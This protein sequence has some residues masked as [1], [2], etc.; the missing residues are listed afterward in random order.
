MNAYKKI[1][2]YILNNPN[3][4]VKY[5]SQEFNT[6]YETVK[7]KVEKMLMMGFLIG[8]YNRLVITKKGFEFL[9]GEVF[10]YNFKPSSLYSLLKN[11]FVNDSAQ[12]ITL[13]RVI[14]SKKKNFNFK[15]LRVYRLLG[16]LSVKIERVRKSRTNK[17]IILLTKQGL[18]FL[19]FY[20]E[21]LRY[22]EVLHDL[23]KTKN[24]SE[25]V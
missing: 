14:L 13:E 21:K 8:N 15:T 12:T 20:D 16:F 6:S 2:E 10:F 23:K 18:D 4:S 11:L 17:Y 19:Q 5:I 3:T 25:V 9:N 7:C 1:L 24:E 22:Y